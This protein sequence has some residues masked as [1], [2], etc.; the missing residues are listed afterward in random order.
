MRAAAV[1]VALAAA[2]SSVVPA[3]AGAWAAVPSS[4]R[5]SQEEGSGPGEAGRAA[6]DG[7]LTVIGL[8]TGQRLVGFRS[9]EPSRPWQLGKV[10]GLK[11]DTKLVG[12][13]FRVQNTKL[14]GVGDKGGFYTLDTRNLA[15]RR[16]LSTWASGGRPL[17]E[18][19]PKI[20]P[21]GK[22]R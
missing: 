8:T 14:Y 12:I 16:T 9:G 19:L 3:S 17:W 6:V 11:K 13:D 18:L 2:V 7:D 15:D 10:S 20:S 1:T 4:D 21:P 22:G 5:T